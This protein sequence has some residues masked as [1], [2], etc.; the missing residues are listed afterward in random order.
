MA[1]I[2]AAALTTSRPWSAEEFTTLLA[3]P[4]AFALGDVRAFALLRV[5]L[6]EAELLAIATDPDHQRH[7]LARAL[8][9]AALVETARHGAARL[10]LEVAADNTGALGLYAE[11]GF[12]TCGRRA[13]YYARNPGPAVDALVLER[14][15]GPAGGD[16][17][18]PDPAKSG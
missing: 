12:W 13:G 11:C 3:S 6:D 4:G 8:M 2:H 17:T 14:A 16:E 9:R 10:F 1:T 5:T 18:A 15:T 7:G